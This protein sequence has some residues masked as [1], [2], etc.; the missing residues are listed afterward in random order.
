MLAE[1]K[2]GESDANKELNQEAAEAID[3]S[4]KEQTILFLPV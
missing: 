3:L 1:S 2:I 4:R